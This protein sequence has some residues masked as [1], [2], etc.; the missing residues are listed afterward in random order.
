MRVQIVQPEAFAQT[1]DHP[2]PAA[3]GQGAHGRRK[4]HR[5]DRRDIAQ[6][7]EEVALG[8]GATVDTAVPVGR[9]RR[10]YRLRLQ[11]RKGSRLYSQVKKNFLKSHKKLKL[12]CKDDFNFHI[13]FA[14]S[15]H[16]N[17]SKIIQF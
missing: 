10:Q 6:L 12:K 17:F 2:A 16:K 4:L 11:L 9:L 14:Q 15:K 7:P 1:V 13:L 3:A 5:L 8:I